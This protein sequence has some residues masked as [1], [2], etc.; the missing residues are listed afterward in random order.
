MKLKFNYETVMRRSSV[1]G[2]SIGVEMNYGK[3]HG[4]RYESGVIELLRGG[5]AVYLAFLIP[6]YYGGQFL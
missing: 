4:V 6:V 1:G 5:W 2:C 3:I